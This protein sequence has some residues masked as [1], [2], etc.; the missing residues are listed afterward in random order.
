M[1]STSCDTDVAELPWRRRR[2][3]PM[4]DAYITPG[5]IRKFVIGKTGAH[6][7]F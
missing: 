5:A 6:A 1:T 3:G 7:S 2:T 4:K